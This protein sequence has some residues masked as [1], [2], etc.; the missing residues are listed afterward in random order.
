MTKSLSCQ[1]LISSLVLAAEVI[2]GSPFECHVWARVENAEESPG[3]ELR[4]LVMVSEDARATQG[5]PQPSV[6]QPSTAWS[7]H[8]QKVSSLLSSNNTA[9]NRPYQGLP[10]HACGREG[11]CPWPSSLPWFL[12]E[13]VSP[14][15]T[16]RRKV[17]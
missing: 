11:L 4:T 10:A 8:P 6:S 16:P 7:E 2:E 1:M 14:P 5:W 9:Q 15:P 17:K 3:P 13:R 12:Q